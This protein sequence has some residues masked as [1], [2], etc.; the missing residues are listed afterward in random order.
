M[1]DITLVDIGN[2]IQ[3]IGRSEGTR[4]ERE[5]ID[6]VDDIADKLEGTIIV[7]APDNQDEDAYTWR[8][9]LGPELKEN[10]F[11]RD[12]DV[13]RMPG[14]YV[15]GIP[16]GKVE[17]RSPL[18]GGGYA[19]RGRGGRFI[20]GF[21]RGI[22]PGDIIPD[23]PSYRTADRTVTKITFG[24]PDTPH[25]AKFVHNG[26]GIHGPLGVPYGP[27]KAPFM[28]Y[29]AHGQWHKRD[30]VMGQK[31]NPYLI[32]SYHEANASYVP[33]EVAQLRLRLGLSI[34]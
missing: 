33:E 34:I 14:R 24:L 12:D 17:G 5:L 32:Y 28:V 10:P 21:G 31:A 4:V 22:T 27:R 8:D 16:G 26:T 6:T 3:L 29:K 25:Y 23:I 15:P 20:K 13:R 30:F 9:R 18:F 11:S 19:V 7:N 2:A 1:I